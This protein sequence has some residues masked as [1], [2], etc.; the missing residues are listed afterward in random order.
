MRLFAHVE[1]THS[2][3]VFHPKGDMRTIGPLSRT[4]PGVVMV[5]RS[6]THLGTIQITPTGGSEFLLSLISILSI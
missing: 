5:K 2:G 6:L 1:V 3:F 4:L